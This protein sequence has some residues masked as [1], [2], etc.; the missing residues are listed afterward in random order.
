MKLDEIGP[1]SEVK[2]EIIK[3]Y[4]SAYTKIL[5]NKQF[6]KKYI[7]ID[8]FAG[9][10]THQSKATGEEVLGT[11]REALKIQPPFHEYHFVDLKKQKAQLLKE[12]AENQKNVYVYQDDCNIALP[13]KI[14][15]RARYDDYHRALCILDPYGLHLDWKLMYE[16]GQMESIDIF[17]NFP[18]MDINMN[19]LKDDHSKVLAKDIERMNRFWG[20]ESWREAGYHTQQPNLFGEQVLIAKEK[21]YLIDAFQKRL[22]NVAGF[23]YVPDPMPMRNSSNAIV[24]WLFFATKQPV[25][26]HIISEI[27]KKYQSVK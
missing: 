18:I 7:Y 27:F 8:A 6:I 21:H 17:I 11:P 20:D 23:K 5:S 14:Y 25:A 3:K 4:A 10:G 19:V 2:I 24:Y 16:A 13:K 9:A 12:L 26:S 22:K 15:P 1:W